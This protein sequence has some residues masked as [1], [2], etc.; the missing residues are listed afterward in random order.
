MKLIRSVAILFFDFF[1]KFIHQKRILNFLKRNKTDIRLFFDVG[2]HKGLYSDLILKN[3]K[4][5]KVFMFEPQKEIFDFIK[6][7]YK[8]K[9]TTKVYNNAV[10]N[11]RIKK[12]YTKY[13]ACSCYM[14]DCTKAVVAKNSK[15]HN[16]LSCNCK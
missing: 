1:D 14:L 8:N 9:K 11:H 13:L 16:S 4:V 10:S 7:K 12:K 15:I 6:K 5:D 3:F 2:P